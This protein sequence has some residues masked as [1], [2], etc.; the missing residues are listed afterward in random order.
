MEASDT[1]T[2]EIL[3][4]TAPIKPSFQKIFRESLS[5]LNMADT[6]YFDHAQYHD[7]KATEKNLASKFYQKESNFISQIVNNLDV[8][9]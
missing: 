9:I 4:D 5:N 7:A 6:S 2:V 3:D 1:I 8:A